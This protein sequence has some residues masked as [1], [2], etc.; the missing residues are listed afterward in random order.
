MAELTIDQALQQGVEAHKAGQVQEADRLYTAILKAQPKHPD[1]NHN[2]GVLAVGVGKVQEALPFF[3][4]ALEANPAKAQFWLSYIDTL[5]KLGKLADGKA[6]LDQAKSQGAKGNGFDQLE[7]RLHEAGEEPLVANQI[8]SE[9]QPKQPNILDTLKLDQAISLAK[10]KAKEGDPEEAKR[11]YQDILAKFPKNKRASDGLKGLAGRPVGKVSTVQDAPTAEL[12][13]LIAL[14]NNGQLALVVEQAQNLTKQYPKAFAVWN[15]MGVSAAQIGQLDQAIFALKRVL[16]IKPD[17]ADAYNN[18]G[19]TL[20]EQGKLEEAI[21]AYNKALVIKPDYADAYYNM[22]VTLQEQGKLE[23]AIEAYNK[24]LAIKPDNA[25]AFNNM[26]NVL[27]EQGKLEEA[28]EAYNKALAIKPDNA[29]AFNNMGVTLKDQ[30]KLEEAIE[31]YNK[32]LAIKPDNAEAYL[33]MGVTLQ[34][35]GKLEEANHALMRAANIIIPQINHTTGTKVSE[36]LQLGYNLVLRTEEGACIKR[37]SSTKSFRRERNCLT[38]FSNQDFMPNAIAINNKD[39]FITTPFYKKLDISFGA[40]YSQELIL[41]L[42]KMEAL[43]IS[44]NDISIFDELFTDD[45][46]LKIIDWESYSQGDEQTDK[47]RIYYDRCAYHA[48]NF[49]RNAKLD[50]YEPAFIVSDT[51]LDVPLGQITHFV[52][53]SYAIKESEYRQL[54]IS[55]DAMLSKGAPNK[56]KYLSLIFKKVGSKAFA[57]YAIIEGVSEVKKAI[58]EQIIFASD[59]MLRLWR[60]W[61]QKRFVTD[62]TNPVFQYRRAGIKYRYDLIS[63]VLQG[64]EN[65]SLI[66]DIGSNAGEVSEFIASLGF[67]VI[68]FEPDPKVWNISISKNISNC[69]LYNSEFDTEKINGGPAEAALLLSVFHRI[70]ALKGSQAAIQELLKISENVQLIIFEGSSHLQ[71]YGKR[72][73]RFGSNDLDQCNRWHMDL[74]KKVLPHWTCQFIDHVPHTST[75]PLRPFY[76]LRKYSGEAPH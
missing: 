14:Y 11:I 8:F 53:A 5:I 19:V 17:H 38:Q 57:N 70:W 50:N 34:E 64:L 30:G 59:Y 72:P 7:Q 18:M 76:I 13:S 46:R 2:M 1:A 49:M 62:E 4:T 15:L 61:W 31:A 47:V 71:R 39:K 36:V 73:P 35:Q 41:A 65:N 75:E 69:R 63:N 68:G 42:E 27:K 67:S 52:V 16:A 28:I 32:A 29:E 44:H 58:D 24:A 56:K 12:Q 43:G 48:Y 37:Y 6:V 66:L 9:P 51:P 3:K 22:G 55:N 26:G 21:E 10:K 33:D 74:F 60:F 40:D 45:E 54:K 20:Q 23:E 25:E